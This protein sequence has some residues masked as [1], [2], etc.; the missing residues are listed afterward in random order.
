MKP[1]KFGLNKHSSSCYECK[2]RHVNCHAHC[3]RYQ[4]EFAK[5]EAIRAENQKKQALTDALYDSK[6]RIKM[7][8]FKRV[9][10]EMTK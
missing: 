5:R 2:D 1:L 7:K 4:S 10:D 9:K 6:N 8:Y 3:E